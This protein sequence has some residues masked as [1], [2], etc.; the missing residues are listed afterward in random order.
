MP[1]PAPSRRTS[2][3]SHTS[4]R[5]KQAPQPITPAK[6]NTFLHHLGRTGSITFAAARAGLPRR[7]LYKRRAA[8][9]AF[10]ARWD[11]ALQ[12]GI[13]R[14]QDDAMRR[15]LHGTERAVFR[16][17]QR[18]GSVQQYDNRLLQFLLRAHRPEVYGERGKA[19]L[20]PLPFDLA[21]RLA[22]AAPRAD[23]YDK[24][25]RAED[26]AKEKHDAKRSKKQGG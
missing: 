21:Q 19:A 9:A 16:N 22:A 15:A 18:V 10:A 12:L 5:P 2:S 24:A 26:A 13:D 11:E 1:R 8:D 4:P 20:P 6:I 3:R 7:A 17:G 25:K 23:A 14:L